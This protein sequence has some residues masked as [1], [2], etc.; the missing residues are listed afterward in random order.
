MLNV[1]DSDSFPK[2]SYYF[3]YETRSLNVLELTESIFGPAPINPDSVEPSTINENWP[4]FN[5]FS[6]V[7]FTVNSPLV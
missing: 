5:V 1:S 7:S 3:D 2:L 4:R 6:D